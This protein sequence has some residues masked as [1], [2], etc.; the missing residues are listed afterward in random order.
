MITLE[1][2]GSYRTMRPT[3]LG[4]KRSEMRFDR[5]ESSGTFREV[6]PSR[7][8]SVGLV[9]SRPPTVGLFYNFSWANSSINAFSAA[10]RRWPLDF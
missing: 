8:W 6:A 10:R 3:N 1:K 7:A 5:C 2:R 9:L 4:N